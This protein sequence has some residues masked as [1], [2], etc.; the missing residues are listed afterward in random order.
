MSPVLKTLC[1][2]ATPFVLAG[3]SGELSTLDPAGPRAANLALL[4]WVMFWGSVVLFA[5]VMILFFLAYFRSALLARFTPAHWIIGGG[6]ILPIPVL[7][8]LTGTALVLGEQLLPH[9]QAPLR[10]GVE[11]SRWEWRFTYPNGVNSAEEVVHI[12]AGQPVDFEISAA[13]VIHSFWVPRLGG[14]IDAVPGHVNVIR[15]E[16]DEPG[17]YWGQCAEYCGEGHDTMFF[18]V[19]AHPPEVFAAMMEDNA[20]E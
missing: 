7:V 20:G 4:W 3:C 9:G 17:T 1:L 19:E 5:L 18:R 10:I 15:L 12:P 8:L 14:K 11:A 16:A 6:L 2:G 13:D